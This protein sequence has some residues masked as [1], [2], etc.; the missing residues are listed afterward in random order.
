L[1]LFLCQQEFI[2]DH[3]KGK[4]DEYLEAIAELSDLRQVRK[5]KQTRAAQT[6]VYWGR[7]PFIF[8]FYFLKN[9]LL[10]MMLTKIVNK[11]QKQNRNH[12]LQFSFEI[13]LKKCV[14]LFLFLFHFGFILFI[15]I[16]RP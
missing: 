11:P 6:R 15:F 13:I 5:K 9:F 14:A 8:I 4:A 7:L 3:Y 16:I 2:E 12:F 1:G 10:I